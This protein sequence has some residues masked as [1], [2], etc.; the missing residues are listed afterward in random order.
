MA[1]TTTKDAPTQAA[2]K[3]NVKYRCV[4]PARVADLAVKEP[5]YAATFVARRSAG[6]GF[7]TLLA[8]TTEQLDTA[9]A[10]FEAALPT[11]LGKERLDT[12][13]A[14]N[15]GWLDPAKLPVVAEAAP[16]T[17]R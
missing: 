5:W 15:L 17:A 10:F 11:L 4:L 16:E 14:I 13:K 12:G 8:A 2:P 6:K 9:K 7:S 3:S 1:K